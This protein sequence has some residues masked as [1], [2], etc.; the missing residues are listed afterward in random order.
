VAAPLALPI[1]PLPEL[2]FF[3][4]TMLP[5]HIF[6]ARYRAM[7]TDCLA[8]D[9]RLAVVGLKPGYE[10]GYEGKPAVYEITGVGRILQWERLPTGRFNVL[11]RGEARARIDRELPTDT[12]YR[13]V[14]AT[15]LDET[16][17]TNPG[18]P[19]LAG[20]VRARCRQ[21]LSAVGRS[22]PNLLATIEA[23][24]QPGELCDQVAAALIPV[25]TTRQALL[26]EVDVERRLERLA[27]ALDDLLSHLTGEGGRA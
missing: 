3:P 19:A 22:G 10:A 18:V 5:L 23:L 12:L 7:I 20:R 24:Q 17:A 4:H 9:R 27:T 13:M 21:V 14:A 1:F 16:G 6:E 2:T 25:P 15:R 8:R 26:E 11:L